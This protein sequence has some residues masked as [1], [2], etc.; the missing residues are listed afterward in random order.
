MMVAISFLCFGVVHTW[1]DIFRHLVM[2]CWCF[3]HTWLDIKRRFH[4]YRRD[5]DT[6]YAMQVI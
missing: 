5:R 3:S 1:L 6:W 2:S 4:G